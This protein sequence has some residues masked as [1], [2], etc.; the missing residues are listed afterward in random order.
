M[1]LANQAVVL[2]GRVLQ[3]DG[4][5]LDTKKVAPHLSYGMTR[6]SGSG[7]LRCDAE[8]RF[9][10]VFDPRAASGEA[11]STKVHLDKFEV[12][13][14]VDGMRV[15]AKLEPR[16]LQIGVNDLGDVQL[17]AEPLVCAGRL[18]GYVA[19]RGR[20][21]LVVEVGR[22]S[23]NDLRWH[24][25]YAYRSRLA[26][27]GTFAVY[28]SQPSERLRMTVVSSHLLPVAP[29]EFA[30]GQRDL[31][32]VVEDGAALELDCL[33]PAGGSLE[34]LAL[35]L[36][37]GPADAS[38]PPE[39][40]AGG[41]R[42]PDP[43]RAR[44]ERRSDEKVRALW[45]GL[46]AG[47]Y[48]LCVELPGHGAALYERPGLVLPLPADASQAPIDLRECMRWVQV[49]LRLADGGPLPRQRWA[50]LPQPQPLTDGAV[51]GGTAQFTT[52]GQL[53]LG[54]SVRELLVAGE[55][56]VPQRVV[57]DGDAVL[58]AMRPWQQLELALAPGTALPEG[59]AVLVSLASSSE[60]PRNTRYRLSGSSGALERLL[61]PDRQ[62]SQASFVDGRATL[63]IGD[64]VHRLVTS[65]QLGNHSLP[66]AR[67]VPGEVVAGA[68]VTI[69]LDADE[70]A[71]AAAALAAQ[72]KAK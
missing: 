67:A 17:Q 44:L 62:Q 69:T 59:T 72:A 65:L 71:A 2:R 22:S 13:A 9:L 25:E 3:P 38:A 27:D 47:T 53:L 19:G 23:K 37:G 54:R 41:A 24:P 50:L 63:P 31:T 55:G 32:I 57:V 1:E 26:D 11:G 12:Q 15:Q 61:A 52:R 8:S 58:V 18:V 21:N 4:T 64:G 20:T 70:L 60:R 10:M 40:P 29:V 51:W 28:G 30:R 5:P 39:N 43:R 48:T 36:R 7:S 6:L 14:E 49:D 35:M 34:E 16:D 45:G 56:F 42:R 68:L 33:L 66:L 46:P